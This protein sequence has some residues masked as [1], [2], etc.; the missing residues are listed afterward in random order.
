MPTDGI[1]EVK[2]M[3]T[4]SLTLNYFLTFMLHPHPHMLTLSGASRQTYGRIQKHTCRYIIK[5]FI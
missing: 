4:S 5:S 2:D 3:I 1:A